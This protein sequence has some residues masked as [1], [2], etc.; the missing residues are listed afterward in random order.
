MTT[1]GSSGVY[2]LEQIVS[3]TSSIYIVTTDGVTISSTLVSTIP[4]PVEALQLGGGV[5]ASSTL[6]FF[7]A[8]QTKT[9]KIAY[10]HKTDSTL[11]A[12]ANCAA[13]T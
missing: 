2:L 1:N 3:G 9:V 11:V 8:I 6:A 4:S 12:V 5:F 7:S 10:L 13:F